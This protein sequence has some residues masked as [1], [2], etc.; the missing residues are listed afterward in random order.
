MRPQA[1]KQKILDAALKLFIERGYHK[2]TVAEIAREAGVSKGLTYNYYESKEELLY[3]IVDHASQKMF[4]VGDQLVSGAGY[5][6]AL[7]NFLDAYFHFLN[8]NREYLSLQLVLLMQPDLKEIVR[9]ML[10]SRAD[11]LYKMTQTMF[12][13]SRVFAPDQAA[14]RLMTELDGIALHYLFVY[15]DYPLEEMI[16]QLFNN[17]K[18]LGK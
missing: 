3:A 16:K 5:Q 1:G 8:S 9:P 17:Y 2:T 15:D 14:K 12:R 7:L 13:R 4:E 11:R 18:N 10:K 6:T